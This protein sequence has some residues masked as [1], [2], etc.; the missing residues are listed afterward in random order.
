[1]FDVLGLT[2]P[3]Y[4]SKNKSKFPKIVY[5]NYVKIAVLTSLFW[6]ATAALV[7]HFFLS[8]G[9]NN[10]LDCTELRRRAE[11]Y[12]QHNFQYLGQRVASSLKDYP[13]V[14]VQD[15]GDCNKQPAVKK[16]AASKVDQ[17][18][19]PGNRVGRE[20]V[21][22]P[23]S[24]AS[25]GDEDDRADLHEHTEY[26]DKSID[27]SQLPDDGLH[28]PGHNGAPVVVPP[29]LEA[30][31]KELFKINQFNL[32]AS[33]MMS[34]NRTLPDIR[35]EAC[36][37]KIYPIDELPDTSI[38]I[39]FHNEAWST[40]IRTL[41][42]IINRSP[43]QLIKEIILVDDASE[44]D[45]LG[46]RL[47]EYITHLPI[48]TYLERMGT[49]N[50]L[51]RSRLRGV[52]RATG[53]TITFLD[54][55]CECTTGW[56]EPLLY[57]VHIDRKSVISPL[58]DVI[59]DSNFEYRLVPDLLAGF[60]WKVL[61]DWAKPRPEEIERRKDDATMPFRTP[62]MAGGLF[63]MDKQY[64][65]EIGSYDEQMNIWGG[66]NLEMSFRLWQCGG[67][68]L[69]SPCSRVG[70]VFRSI[71]P[72]TFPEGT[73]KTVLTN[74]MRTMEV[75][76]GDHKKFYYKSNPAAAIYEVGDLT[77][78]LKLK[79]RL[80][81]KNFVWYLDHVYPD[82]PLPRNFYSVGK[83]GGGGCG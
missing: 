49:R 74:Q 55:H 58:I 40:L 54:A 45:Y 57:Q 13:V 23:P 63:T 18:I 17:F 82:S 25:T 69:I 7:A 75:W 21:R 31:A 50:G 5:K 66:E 47:D 70:H 56:L 34:P 80:K 79:E 8:D 39:V 42:S 33:D 81:C 12:N 68:V 36:K 4:D 64:F 11:L 43:L 19:H 48:P 20:A 73:D 37:A 52:S 78:R 24:S 9:F 77:E 76:L 10:G 29:E 28:E 46:S 26:D 38:I 44:R 2:C 72:Y 83:V 51:V 1:M 6:L 14:H 60:D 35:N 15:F 67:Q 65:Y 3:N 62:A 32:V 53:Q 61:F 41:W 71:S 22:P 16:K 27:R 59:V 30:E